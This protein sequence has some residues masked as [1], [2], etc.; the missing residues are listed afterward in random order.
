MKQFTSVDTDIKVEK[1]DCFYLRNIGNEQFE[2]AIAVARKKGFYKNQKQATCIVLRLILSEKGEILKSSFSSELII[3]N[4]SHDFT[5]YNIILENLSGTKKYF[6][7]ET[8]LQLG[9]NMFSK[10]FSLYS[11]EELMECLMT[12]FTHYAKKKF[13]IDCRDYGRENSPKNKSYRLELYQRMKR[14]EKR[15]P[16]VKQEKIAA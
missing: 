1:E 12:F 13:K 6:F 15:Q 8:L 2:L 5:E 14:R 3:L 4:C 10:N 16:N 11:A 7:L 9:S